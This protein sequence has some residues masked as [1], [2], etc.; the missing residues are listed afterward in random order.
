MSKNLNQLYPAPLWN[1]FANICAHPHPS[2]HEE[3]ILAWLKEWAKEN[4]IDYAQD[5]TG[6]ILF[7]KPATP[8]MEN[9]V[10]VVLQA[11]I[12][13][14]PQ[15]NSDVKHDFL[16]DPI[17]PVVGDDGWVRASGTTLG[18]DNGIGV[19][20]AM[21]VLI[22]D[23]AQHGPIEVLITV[24]EET[25]M[26]GAFGLKSGFVNAEIL[27]NLDSEEEG[28]LFVGCAGGLDAT[29]EFDYKT[30][31]AKEGMVGY[32]FAVTGLK[33]GHSGM[34]IVLGR[35]NANKVMA[36]FLKKAT[37][38][39][40]VRISTINGGSL[41]NA[42][43]REAFVSL[44]VPQ[45]QVAPFEKYFNQ[46]SE[47][48]TAEFSGTEPQMSLQLE[49]QDTPKTL[50]TTDWQQ[51]I[52]NL[53]F[54]IPNGVLRMSDSM[55]GLVET[56][57]NL[58]TVKIADGKGT[59]GNLMRSSVES[60]KE[61]VG[62]K[63]KAIAELAGVQCSLTGGYSGWKPNMDSPILKTMK[64]VYLKKYGVEPKISAI[65][66]GLECGL[67]SQVYPHW[68]MISFGPT[69]Q[70]PHSPD[71]KVEIASVGKFYDYL[72]ETLKHI[73]QK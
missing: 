41:R 34:D 9:R 30:E 21:A 40:G 24:D 6:N 25:G 38:Q 28:E 22:D 18:A 3:K 19:A 67:F 15:A 12:D 32:Q 20:A 14:V 44:A 4:K 66:A 5:E 29:F 47:C 27:I 62:Q 69:I 37:E 23:K 68:D 2:K 63:M 57:T 65:H 59:I 7:R 73:P 72:V 52:I 71:E 8:G 11:H 26:T 43:P 60:A 35:A 70:F 36:R 53:V 64:E 42:I 45:D 1:I 17:R 10:P 39:F 61:A 56:S 49:K 55:P 13:M 48:I 46:F 50:I 54:A 33:G 51:K 31:P 16:T 58:A